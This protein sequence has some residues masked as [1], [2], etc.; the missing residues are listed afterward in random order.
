M[1]DDHTYD[2]FPEEGEVG[3]FVGGAPSGDGLFDGGGTGGMIGVEPE[4]EITGMATTAELDGMFLELNAHWQQEEALERL[5]ASNS[6][7]GETVIQGLRENLVRTKN[8]SKKIKIFIDMD[9]LAIEDARAAEVAL[10]RG[11]RQ[12]AKAIREQTAKLDKANESFSS[13]V[14]QSTESAEGFAAEGF[15]TK[16]KEAKA[17]AKE[18]KAGLKAAQKIVWEQM[19]IVEDSQVQSLELMRQ[20]VAQADIDRA[21][22][23]QAFAK[24]EEERF[25]LELIRQAALVKKSSEVLDDAKLALAG[26]NHVKLVKGVGG[27]L[28]STIG[29][30]G[31]GVDFSK[32]IGAEMK[33]GLDLVT[34][35]YKIYFDRF[36]QGSEK[37]SVF[38]KDGNA[39]VDTAVEGEAAKVS[40][41]IRHLEQY[42]HDEELFLQKAAQHLTPSNRMWMNTADEFASIREGEGLF[43]FKVMPYIAFAMKSTAK[44]GMLGVA[45][46]AQVLFSEEVATGIFV[47]GGAAIE[48]TAA[49]IQFALSAEVMVAI[50]TV[51][52]TLDLFRDG[53]TWKWVDDIL[54][55]IGLSLSMFESMEATMNHYPLFSK[56]VKNEKATNHLKLLEFDS[57]ELATT[58][59]FWGDLYV[60]LRNK[61]GHRLPAYKKLTPFKAVQKIPG[62]YIDLKNHPLESDQDI[63]NCQRLEALTSMESKMSM[64]TIKSSSMIESWFPRRKGY[65]RNLQDFPAYEETMQWPRL[66][67]GYAVQTG[68]YFS[69]QNV[70]LTI[71]ELFRYLAV[72]GEHG[73]VY[74]RAQ[75]RET[76]LAGIEANKKDLQRWLEPSKSDPLIWME[77]RAWTKTLRGKK[78]LMYGDMILLAPEMFKLEWDNDLPLKQNQ[79]YDKLMTV[80]GYEDIQKT[81]GRYTYRPRDRYFLE[82]ILNTNGNNRG[83]LEVLPYQAFTRGMYTP[84]IPDGL[85]ETFSSGGIF[86]G[87][88]YSKY[89]RSTKADIE[90]YKPIYDKGVEFHKMLKGDAEV[91]KEKWKAAELDTI[92]ES[93]YRTEKPTRTVWS[94]IYRYRQ[95]FFMELILMCNVMAGKQ[96]ATAWE[97]Y[98][99]AKANAHVPLM[100]NS[101]HRVAFMGMFAQLSFDQKTATAYKFKKQIEDRFGGPLLENSLVSTDPHWGAASWA[102]GIGQAIAGERDVEE[103]LLAMFGEISARVY[104]MNKPRV[105][106][107]AFSGGTEATSWLTGAKFTTGTFANI[108]EKEDGTIVDVKMEKD[109]TDRSAENLQKDNGTMMVHKGFMD[110]ANMIKEGLNELVAEYF[111]KYEIQEVFMTGHGM[112]AALVQLNAMMIPR[113]PIGG[114]LNPLAVG[115]GIKGTPQF[116]NPNCYMFSSPAI[117]DERF[118]KQFAKWSGESVQ[119]W[120]DG[121]IIIQLP[122]FLLPHQVQSKMAFDE[123]LNTLRAMAEKDNVFGS[124]LFLLHTAVVHLDLPPQLDLGNLFD[125]YKTFSPQRLF[126]VAKS[127]YNASNE[128]RMKRGG[129]VFLRLRMPG[130][131]GFDETTYDSGNSSASFTAIA[132]TPHL[133]A[134]GNTA[135]KLATVINQ[136]NFFVG[137]HPDLFGIDARDIPSWAKTGKITSD[138]PGP[139]VGPDTSAT[140]APGPVVVPDVKEVA[141]H[142]MDGTARIIGY[143]KTKHWHKPWSIV[144]K[145]DVERESGVLMSDQT[146]R[147]ISGLV[148][149]GSVKRRKMDKAEQSYRGEHYL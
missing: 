20:G 25:G 34:K 120:I 121:D 105:M 69:E 79:Y 85:V 6:I 90:K 101:V 59:D 106:V 71:A 107:I 127:V 51:Q 100:M 36:A 38:W 87:R 67:E 12:Y 5:I 53:M 43:V 65:L 131:T 28:A 1:A 138:A 137:K 76:R 75:T 19:R 124:V 111:K 93:Y 26:S 60:K 72:S 14:V 95:D 4:I 140:P 73:S 80:E 113:L 7:V 116:K 40:D 94:Y 54:R 143:A 114:K 68:G 112:G 128:N 42:A 134:R 66:E 24:V 50:F 11:T 18:A 77:I 89:R 117:G 109:G 58:L 39:S 46:I 149:A 55:H 81:T 9:V 102:L 146:K 144:D 84:I 145:N 91:M 52:I 136:L 82:N 57:I 41:Q 96:R 74:N 45:K 78:G 139:I 70:D 99:K 22:Q 10:A 126:R 86:S 108:H 15:G 49:I 29:D 27:L 125:K 118:V 129:E 132:T 130:S 13:F 135:H 110:A 141:Q 104:V 115:S 62:R 64:H 98:L 48:G 122:P 92:W 56:T 63:Q 97:D 31:K 3:E 30:V 8:N 47:M 133:L 23:Q 142:L 17:A 147:V 37:I 35:G 21:L 33:E 44:L 61:D 32:K 103:D 16:L 148:H 119:V 83:V 88:F 2:F 123:S